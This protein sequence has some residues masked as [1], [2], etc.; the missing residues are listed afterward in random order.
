MKSNAVGGKTIHPGDEVMAPSRVLHLSNDIFGNDAFELS[1]ER[2]LTN[3]ASPATKGYYPFGGGR[4][5]CPGRTIAT[6]EVFSFVATAP[7][8][9]K[10]QPAKGKRSDTGKLEVP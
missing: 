5:L 2:W 6:Q 4:T 8:R 3:K 9:F 7:Y 10:I 1:T